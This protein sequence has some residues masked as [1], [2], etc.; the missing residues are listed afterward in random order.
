MIFSYKGAIDV[1]H[2]IPFIP[3][4][5]PSIPT[6]WAIPPISTSIKIDANLFSQ[7]LCMRGINSL[8]YYI[9]C[10]FRVGNIS[11]KRVILVEC[12]ELHDFT[13]CTIPSPIFSLASALQ[14]TSPGHPRCTTSAP[15]FVCSSPGSVKIIHFPHLQD[16]FLVI[17]NSPYTWPRH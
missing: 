15:A 11:T 9:E 12:K 14:Y 4:L 3:W 6:T 5:I 17:S 10:N 8:N 16:D 1:W 7:H 13:F 2:I